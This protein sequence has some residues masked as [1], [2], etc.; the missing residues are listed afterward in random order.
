MQQA[1]LG[2][3]VL[4]WALNS[5]ICTWSKNKLAIPHNRA[6]R[7]RFIAEGGY[8]MSDNND[9]GDL[10]IGKAGEQVQFNKG[11]RHRGCANVD[12]VS[13]TLVAEIWQHINRLPK[14]SSED[15]IVRPPTIISA[16][17]LRCA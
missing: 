4:N 15:D 6:E 2:L 12:G 9:M 11:V 3:K 10:H 8:Y 17:L 5:V 1:Q 7:W 14:P 16:N 13:Y